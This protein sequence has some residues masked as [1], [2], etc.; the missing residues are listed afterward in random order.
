MTS[1]SDDTSKGFG[2]RQFL[3]LTGG[4]AALAATAATAVVSATSPA[5][6]AMS[7]R[8]NR[9]AD[10]PKATGPRCV[11]VGGG[12][13]GL[14]LAKYLKKENPKFD[15]VMVEPNYLFMSPYLT[16]LWL[17]DVIDLKF[18]QYSFC[19]AARKGNYTWLQGKLID[20]DREKK[21]AYTS[22]GYI[23]YNFIAL[24]PGIDYNYAS[25]GI[26]DPAMVE[27]CKLTYPAGFMPG[28]EIL[29]I[30][31]K[32]A[33]FE[34]G[35]FLTTVPTGN[36]RCL[37]A[38]Y[39]RACLIG[40]YFKRNKIKGKILLLDPG[41]KPFAP[42]APGFLAAFSELYKDYVDYKPSTT[43]KSVDPIKKTVTTDFDTIKFD[44]AAIYPRVRAA[45]LIEDL[46]LADMKSP[47]F[48]ADIDP[49]KYFCKGDKTCYVIGDARPM[50]FSKSGNTA[51]SEAHFV[52]KVI[53]AAAAGKDMDWV[54][55]QT[56]CY[57]MV[58]GHPEESIMVAA[59]YNKVGFGFTDVQ[60]DNKRSEAL[61]KA[62]REWGAGLYRDM[63]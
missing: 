15:V 32:L 21:R 31:E 48:E 29:T 41:E 35:V 60:L 30:K 6:A 45:K 54:S 38:P 49:Y 34:G 14:T 40:D 47:Q 42:K 36:Y 58:N 63:F 37:P 5:A 4:T 62:T 51:N 12:T 25:I 28:S 23:D 39:E 19:D 10:L 33:Q 57:S 43:I 56:V 17:D 59:K 9:P 20:L 8:T 1:S 2:R 26:T 44:D 61:G 50:P 55:P 18:V 46:G 7:G 52:A 13:A 3:Q 11:V 27:Y 24:A 53:A 22:E 16:N